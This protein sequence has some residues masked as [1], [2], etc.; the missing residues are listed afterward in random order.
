VSG[1]T[2]EVGEDG[3]RSRCVGRNGVHEVSA[4]VLEEGSDGYV[5]IGFVSSRLKRRLNAGGR[6][7][8]ETMDRLAAEWLGSRGKTLGAKPAAGSAIRK[9]EQARKLLEQASKEMEEQR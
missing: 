8:A 6:I 1:R 7:S 4:V 2:I 3:E 5:D 9:I